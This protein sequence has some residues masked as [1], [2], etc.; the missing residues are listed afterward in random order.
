MAKTFAE[1]DGIDTEGKG[2][3]KVGRWKLQFLNLIS[4]MTYYCFCGLLFF[5]SEY[6]VQPIL[7]GRGL[8]KGMNTWR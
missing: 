8:H 1:E 6:Q 7:E 5:T 4:E 3:G 2:K